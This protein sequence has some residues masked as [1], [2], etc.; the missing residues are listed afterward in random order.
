MHTCCQV[1]TEVTKIMCNTKSIAHIHFVALF[2]IDLMCH[3]S[4]EVV[5]PLDTWHASYAF[6]DINLV[7]KNQALRF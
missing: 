7:S 3:V 6:G 4:F 1:I 5:K 2:F